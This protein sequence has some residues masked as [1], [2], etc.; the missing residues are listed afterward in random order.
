MR[1]RRAFWL[2]PELVGEVSTI[3][4]LANSPVQLYIDTSLK[5]LQAAVDVYSLYQTHRNTKDMGQHLFEIKETHE[6]QEQIIRDRLREEQIRDIEKRYNSIK[7]RITE[8]EMADEA[9]D[10][11]V[12]IIE[13][14][15]REVIGI[16]SAMKRDDS[17]CAV[18]EVDE[19]YRRA[20]RSYNNIISLYFIQ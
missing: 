11:L 19:L 13:D 1:K 14:N 12:M 2:V 15:L 17:F 18:C 8:L 6:E 3:A 16:T 4:S 7:D 10:S 20:L 5:V 9:V